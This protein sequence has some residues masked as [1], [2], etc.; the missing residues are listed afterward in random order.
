MGIPEAPDLGL[1]LASLS[2]TLLGLG[3][4]AWGWVDGMVGKIV[5]LGIL[6]LVGG[7]GMGR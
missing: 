2:T 6:M 4:L 3:L 5:F 1:I 7:V